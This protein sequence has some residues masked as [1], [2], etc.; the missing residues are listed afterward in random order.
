MELAAKGLAVSL[1]GV[2]L[3]HLPAIGICSVR[4]IA[5]SMAA[6]SFVDWPNVDPVTAWISYIC[7]NTFIGLMSFIILMNLI[8]LLVHFCR[9]CITTLT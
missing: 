2:N 6:L 8:G 3:V 9:D 1:A 5:M 7:L 4:F